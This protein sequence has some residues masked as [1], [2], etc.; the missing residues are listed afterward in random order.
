MKYCSFFRLN[1]KVAVKYDSLKK[2]SELNS[3]LVPLRRLSVLIISLAGQRQ[4]GVVKFSHDKV[5]NVVWTGTDYRF[6]H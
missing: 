3:N 1:Q 4:L 6:H 2:M 5:L